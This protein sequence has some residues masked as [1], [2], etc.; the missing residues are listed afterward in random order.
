MTFPLMRGFDH[1]NVAARLDPVTAVRDRELGER[2]LRYPKLF[3]AGSPDFGHAVQF[4]DEWRIGSLG[5]DDPTSA[6]YNLAIDLRT[7]AASEA[8]PATLQAM[9]AAASRLD[10]EDGEQLAKD[11]WEIG[12]RRYRIIRI[13]KFILI[14]DRVM[15][16]PRSTDADL[17]SDGLLHD[18]LLDPAAPCGQWEAQLRLNLVGR[19]PVPGSVPDDIRTE[20]L[21]A[22]R[23]HPGVVL[24][25]PT[26]I[27]LE[28]EGDAWAPLTGGDDPEE[29]RDRLAR[30]FTGLLPRLREFQG[31]PASAAELAEW[32]AIADGIRATPGHS[33]SVRGREFRT[34]RVGRMLRLGRDGPE[35]PRPS[36][37]ERYGLTTGA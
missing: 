12:D 22:I 10:P 24:L 5:A 9:L 29:T 23:T 17:A 35:S 2:I 19:M 18:H 26:F 21:H 25:P 15:E 11:E 36:D 4:G 28:I 27:G 20:A 14:G 32:T 31:D 13:E 1:I 30:H 8:V 16:P 7:A 3:P 6:R 33:F 34:V 37:Q